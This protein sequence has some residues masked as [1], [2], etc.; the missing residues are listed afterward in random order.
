VKQGRWLVCA[1]G[2]HR[3]SMG[4]V[5]GRTTQ[6]AQGPLLIQPIHKEIHKHIV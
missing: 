1:H 5:Y 6:K 2:T 3:L 4:V